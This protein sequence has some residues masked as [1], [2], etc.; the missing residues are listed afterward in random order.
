[1]PRQELSATQSFNRVCNFLS[2][3][4]IYEGSLRPI[5]THTREVLNNTWGTSVCLF[6]VVCCP[7]L[8]WATFSEQ[9]ITPWPLDV[10]YSS[11]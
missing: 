11:L 4:C 7:F 10:R 3:S 2:K 1:M 9:H 5:V 6:L 8:S